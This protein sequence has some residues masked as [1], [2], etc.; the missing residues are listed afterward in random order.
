MVI[1]EQGPVNSKQ[2][3]SVL[4]HSLDN[5]FSRRDEKNCSQ[6]TVYSSLKKKAA[7]TLAEVLITLGIIGVVAAMTLPTLINNYQKNLVLNKLKQAY[8]QIS[9][10]VD[11]ASVEFD[12]AP[13]GTWGFDCNDE[14]MDGIYYVQDS[15]FHRAMKKIALKMYPK[16]DDFSKAFCYEGKEYKAYAGPDGYPFRE[17]RW[18]SKESWSAKIPNG[19]CVVWN[20]YAWAGDV[21]GRLLIDAD[22]PYNGDNILGKDVYLFEYVDPNSGKGIGNSGRAIMP[23]GY[24]YGRPSDGCAKMHNG[25]MC[26]TIIMNNGWSYPKNYPWW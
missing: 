4:S 22:G 25:H 23:Y 20:R 2:F 7:F 15:C 14:T 12:G 6:F 13:L 11:S 8:A 16:P 10:A 24:D 9:T 18:V 3:K 26:A 5:Q 1:S 17:G 19:A 21:R